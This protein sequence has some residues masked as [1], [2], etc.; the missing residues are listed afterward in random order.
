MSLMINRL[1]NLPV[2]TRIQLSYGFMD[3]QTLVLSG[4]IT[5][6]DDTAMEIRDEQGN[7][8]FIDF[9]TV[10]FFSLLPGSPMQEAAPATAQAAVQP[11]APVIPQT[12][13]ECPG[14]IL[15]CQKNPDQMSV[16][17]SDQELKRGFDILSREEKKLL[18][19]AVDSFFYGV[20]C[21]SMEKR[22]TAAL[23][24]R[25]ILLRQEAD[26]Y[27]WSEHACR[28]VA[29]MSARV[30]VWESGLYARAGMPEEAALC[31]FRSK[32][33]LA[34][35]VNA[36]R[37]LMNPENTARKNDMLVILAHACA[38]LEDVS[39][40][41][42]L[43]NAGVDIRVLTEDLLLNMKK[44]PQAQSGEDLHLL[45]E[46]YPASLIGAA[47]DRVPESHEPEMLTGVISKVLWVNNTGEITFPLDD[48]EQTV[49]FRYSQVTDP[50]VQDKLTS[51]GTDLVR[52]GCM[53][54]FNLENDE[55]VQIQQASTPLNLAHE[56]LGEE[57]YFRAC[58][59]CRNA[60]GTADSKSAMALM[61][62]AAVASGDENLMQQT[63]A[64]YE[65]HQEL[66]PRYSKSLSLLGQLYHALHNL[67]LSLQLT[68]DALED[69]T[70]PSRLRT[71]ILVQY[72]TYAMRLYNETGS[73]LWLRGLNEKA[74]LW[75][76]IFREELPGEINCIKRHSRVLTWK[77]RGLLALGHVDEAEAVY[78]LLAQKF[79]ED[80]KLQNI[81]ALICQTRQQILEKQQPPVR[82][83]PAFTVQEESGEPEDCEDFE[84]PCLDTTGSWEDL[85]VSTGEFVQR[86]LDADG[87][88]RLA[89]Q[90]TALKAGAMLNPELAPL[91]DTLSAAVNSPLESTI[92]SAATL[93]RLLSHADSGYPVLNRY[94]AACVYLRTL[95]L[96]DEA[97]LWMRQC[98]CLE[99]IPEI[100]GVFDI[101]EAFRRRTGQAADRYAAY[102]DHI[103][104]AGDRS[105]QDLLSRARRLYDTYITAPVRDS[106]TFTRFVHTKALA[107][108]ALK[109]YLEWVMQENRDALNYAEDS[110]RKQF[111]AS[112]GRVSP[113][114]VDKFIISVWD[115][116]AKDYPNGD[117]AELQ[118]SR[119]NALRNSV[120]AITGLVCDCYRGMELPRIQSRSE[121]GSTNFS[122]MLPGLIAALEAVSA[123]CDAR[124][125]ECRS[126]QERTGLFL[127]RY[128][129]AELLGKLSGIW[130]SNQ[131][132]YLFLDFLRTNQVP[133]TDDFLPDFSGM[134]TGTLGLV[135]RVFAHARARKLDS[136]THIDRIFSRDQLHFRN[137]DTAELIRRQSEITGQALRM[138]EADRY[139]SQAGLMAKLEFEELRQ[140]L[141][142]VGDTEGEELLLWF[143]DHCLRTLRF[144]Y[145][146]EAL[147]MLRARLQ[148][149][150]GADAA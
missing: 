99:E 101:L 87:P 22:N 82:E 108:N 1:R 138:P 141:R 57:D 109:K 64:F 31:G 4:S 56:A 95:F 72:M 103:H 102:R 30:G 32:D 83:I 150:E 148:S 52:R 6:K 115:S 136:Q 110:F 104:S 125:A 42:H 86:V 17:V 3:G 80:P 90:L 132:Q 67:E 118:G 89:V 121:E 143:Y 47:L 53:V 43:K 23:T 129:A 96:H 145:F 39:A 127:L 98:I 33:Y 37:S 111:L 120:R 144:G 146:A 114:K 91:Y 13:P 20:R 58:W 142:E 46:L 45:R 88:D 65:A 92:Y 28:L 116:T 94:A 40:L 63:A 16:G 117:S 25:R 62:D 71:A 29:Q 119:R 51:L 93:T 130:Q 19:K 18:Q 61:V 11:S 140:A 34:A 84:V 123:H 128:T 75:L 137:F 147:D 2:H 49:P 126:P 5:D 78:S 12:P 44:Q 41:E 35:G 50:A 122:T 9:A 79:P 85:A 134:L 54:R 77:I 59:F 124:T 74:D 76:K 106:G 48:G 26:G 55:A 60:L 73:E 139:I 10:R 100:S 149:R 27:V 8:F 112:D 107:H 36:A 15:L 24:A 21:N 81:S 66:Y 70:T 133:L 38:E 7:Q 97:P 131:E 113:E 69:E 14:K 135:N 68:E 105:H